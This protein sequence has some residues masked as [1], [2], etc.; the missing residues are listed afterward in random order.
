MSNCDNYTEVYEDR[1][2]QCYGSFEEQGLVYTVVR[3]LDLPYIEC[4][5][6]ITLD[7]RRSIITEAGT[8][9]GRNKKVETSGMVLSY[10]TDKCTEW[11]WETE[12][13]RDISTVVI[14]E[15]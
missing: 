15:K 12:E 5:V 13:N 9:C 6:G 7:G 14:I 4:F 2:Y 8:S 10:Q 3:R 1:S 11:Y